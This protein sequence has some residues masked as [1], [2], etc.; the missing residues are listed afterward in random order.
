M[1]RIGHARKNNFSFEVT[2]LWTSRQCYLNWW[3][4]TKFLTVWRKAGKYGFVLVTFWRFLKKIFSELLK[5]CKRSLRF[6]QVQVKEYPFICVHKTFKITWNLYL[7]LFVMPNDRHKAEWEL[8]WG[9]FRE[10]SGKF[11]N[12]FWRLFFL[13]FFFRQIKLQYDLLVKKTFS[14]SY[15][16]LILQIIFNVAQSQCGKMMISLSPK[17]KKKKNCE[18]YYLAITKFLPKKYK[19]E[20]S[21]FS[22]YSLFGNYRNLLPHFLCL[23]FRESNVFT[24]QDTNELIWRNLFVWQ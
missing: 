11:I 14:K 7:S 18:I 19:G 22:L 1:L 12:S 21:Q 2:R 10:N 5:S 23:N 24:K 13:F 3:L 9:K 15:C 8:T 16:T 4:G 17:K 6:L 20:F